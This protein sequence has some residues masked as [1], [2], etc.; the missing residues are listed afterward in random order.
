MGVLRTLYLALSDLQPFSCAV[1]V[2]KLQNGLRHSP[3]KV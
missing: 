1:N 3:V 2:S